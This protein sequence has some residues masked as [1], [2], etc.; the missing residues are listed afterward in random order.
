MITLPVWFFPPW[1][2]KY[3]ATVL[4]FA[5]GRELGVLGVVPF[6]FANLLV[7]LGYSG[8][9]GIPVIE[10]PLNAIV[11][12]TLCE[13]ICREFCFFYGHFMHYVECK[14]VDPGHL[15]LDHFQ[16]FT[17]RML[18]H[19][20]NNALAI[21]FPANFYLGAAM[22]IFNCGYFA[23]YWAGRDYD[24]AFYYTFCVAVHAGVLAF[25]HF[26]APPVIPPKLVPQGGLFEKEVEEEKSSSP[27]CVVSSNGVVGVT[28]M[29]AFPNCLLAP[30]ELQRVILNGAAGVSTDP[31]PEKP[32]KATVS[33]V[34]KSA[35]YDTK[36]LVDTILK[37]T[38][39]TPYA[40]MLRG[41]KLMS[42]GDVYDMVKKFLV[43][44]V[45]LFLSLT[46][47]VTYKPFVMALWR[48]VKELF[49]HQLRSAYS[50][51]SNI[52]DFKEKFLDPIFAIQT[53]GFGESFGNFIEKLK[54]ARDGTVDFTESFFYSRLM[55][56]LSAILSSATAYGFGVSDKIKLFMPRGINIATR[57]SIPDICFILA[58]TIIDILDVG[59]QYFMDG[60][61]LTKAHSGRTYAKWYA[62]IVKLAGEEQRIDTSHGVTRDEYLRRLTEAFVF[63]EEMGELITEEKMTKKDIET[64]RVARKDLDRLYN[65]HVVYGSSGTRLQPFCA[66]LY[67]QPGVGKTSLT[68]KIYQLYEA[69]TECGTPFCEDTTYVVSAKSKYWDGFTRSKRYI[70]LDDVGAIRIQGG[71]VSEDLSTFI[72]LVNNVKFTPDQAALPDK[73]VHDAIP[74][75]V[76]MT[77]NTETF[78]ITTAFTAVSAVVRRLS[79]HIKIAVKRE[80]SVVEFGQNTGRLDGAKLAAAKL[81]NPKVDPWHLQVRVPVL[82][83]TNGKEKLDCP[84]E[85][86]VLCQGSFEEIRRPLARLMAEHYSGQIRFQDAMRSEAKNPYLKCGCFAD[87]G[88][89]CAVVVQGGTYVSSMSDSLYLLM[90]FC[91]LTYVCACLSPIL[92]AARVF[93]VKS[94]VTVEKAQLM[95]QDVEDLG[96]QVEERILSKC[97]P[98][99]RHARYVAMGAG[100][101]AGVKVL[102][103]LMRPMLEVQGSTFSRVKAPPSQPDPYWEQKA[104]KLE[105]THQSRTCSYE[106]MSDRVRRNNV[107][108]FKL[109]AEEAT[110][111]NPMH[112]VIKLAATCI[113]GQD[114]IFPNHSLID[115]EHKYPDTKFIRTVV[116]S[117]PVSPKFS[118]NFEIGKRVVIKDLAFV[119]ILDMI[120]R[121]DITRFLLP[122]PLPFKAQHFGAMI[123]SAGITPTTIHVQQPVTTY[124]V[125]HLGEMIIPLPVFHGVSKMGACGVPLVI[126]AGSGFAIVGFHVAGSTT[127]PDFGIAQHLVQDD[128]K[129]AQ[130][131]LDTLYGYPTVNCEELPDLTCY[132]TTTKFLPEIHSKNS[133]HFVEIQSADIYGELDLPVNRAKTD[134]RSSMIRPDVEEFLGPCDFVAPLFKSGWWKN[135]DEGNEP[136]YVNPMQTALRAIS[137]ANV[138]L[139]PSLVA[140]ARIEYLTRVLF[141]IAEDEVPALRPLSDYQAINGVPGKKFIRS[142]NKN[143]GGGFGMFTKKSKYLVP[144]PTEDSPDGVTWT[145]KIWAH[146]KALEDRYL[147]GTV[148]PIFQAHLK[149]EPRVVK[150]ETGLPKPARVFTGTPAAFSHLVRKY[151]LPIVDLMQRYNLAFECAVGVDANSADWGSLRD[152]IVFH[153]NDRLV[154]GDYAKY[155]KSL[156]GRL[157]LCAF[158]ILIEIAEVS[159][160]YSPEELRIMWNIAY[161]SSFPTVYLER[162]VY[163]FYGSLPSGHPLTVI[164]NSIC[165]S[166]LVRIGFGMCG[167]EIDDFS[168]LVS[169]L[170]YGDDNIYSTK[171]DFTHAKLKEA[172]G[173]CGLSYTLADKTNR[174][175]DFQSLSECDFLKRAFIEREGRVFAPLSKDSIIRCLSLTYDSSLSE[176]EQTRETLITMLR[177]MYQYGEEEYVSFRNFAQTVCAKYGVIHSF[178]T[179]PEMDE[180]MKEK[181][182]ETRVAP[183]S[184][185]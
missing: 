15:F 167:F 98:F 24:N 81:L 40:R 185:Y 95:M 55:C 123:E 20:G 166:L 164:I 153:G 141:S 89:E 168:N 31:P 174:A 14:W 67:G 79:V 150:P 99:F 131:S 42:Q 78:G 161:D 107:F 142:I 46:D 158:S 63:A 9:V 176:L 104:P 8:Y 74:H 129:R 108:V 65:K 134:V 184:C 3:F 57:V 77:T 145:P 130:A 34:V 111:T 136:H 22:R 175:V 84:F 32:I 133:A 155:D 177:E 19:M 128:A 6:A 138:L 50:Y 92:E 83:R 75:I 37:K 62:E 44:I 88:C 12:S 66:V 109:Y 56:L 119:R 120:P 30:D 73:G 143:A 35:L 10:D 171:V 49:P 96:K 5:P 170:S 139:D 102:Q 163:R 113:G 181:Y 112:N 27:I 23:Y 117:G 121:K 21:Y 11:I 4:S 28:G 160:N 144:E 124:N 59:Y 85:F 33:T 48:T 70:T 71:L 29:E 86:K 43:C 149:N 182:E 36:S 64:Y 151:F 61:H 97:T 127:G 47:S 80:F 122:A 38:F 162:V 103:M 146:I 106:T 116:I 169:F 52:T 110:P 17:F 154:A 180:L 51:L 69:S 18:W 179:Y 156:P 39:R 105:L 93:L 25:R 26:V 41:A 125:P 118:F 1:I 60:V 54:E 90:S 114:F 173:Q 178:L 137:D 94:T 82:Q 91:F 140:A 7:T 183:F 100:L 126:K 58:S 16:S 132:N 148:Q 2:S 72:D 115:I 152:F 172:L 53:Q 135:D 68:R 13:E 101:F 45:D 76:V 157:L 87:D 165:N 147:C 159:G